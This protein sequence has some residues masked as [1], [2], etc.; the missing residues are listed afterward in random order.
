MAAKRIT[1]YLATNGWSIVSGLA[2]G[3]DTLAHREALAAN[4]HTV[5]VLA[6]GLDKVYP[7]ENETSRARSSTKGGLSFS[8]QPFGS[9]ATVSNLVQRDRLQCGM[10]VATFVMQTDVVGG[11]MHTVIS[12]LFSTAYS[13]RHFPTGSHA[14]EEKSRGIVALTSRTGPDIRLLRNPPSE[15]VSLLRTAFRSAHTPHRPIRS[16]DDYPAVLAELDAALT[17]T[18]TEPRCPMRMA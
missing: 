14:K 10:S 15:Y 7:R 12:R 3:V 9:P 5:A 13:L 16:S 4:A 17:N 6:N 11:S 2:I 1:N 8:E 18:S